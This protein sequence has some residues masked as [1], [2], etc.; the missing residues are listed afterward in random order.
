[1]H[2]KYG[3]LS[4]VLNYWVGFPLSRILTHHLFIRTE[5]SDNVVVP[6]EKSTDS[7][8]MVE[9]FIWNDSIVYTTV[10]R[11]AD[12]FLLRKFRLTTTLRSIFL[13]QHLEIREDLNIF[14][15]IVYVIIGGDVIKRGVTA[16]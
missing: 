5:D 8:D 11:T 10:Q 4:N 14:G 15:P 16:V 12:W 9:C 13:K 1:M 2:Y 7:M 3:R 6:N